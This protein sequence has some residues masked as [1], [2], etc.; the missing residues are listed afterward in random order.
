MDKHNVEKILNMPMPGTLKEIRSFVCLAGY[1]RRFIEGF[2]ELARPLTSLQSK[3]ACARLKRIG[4]NRTK[5]ELPEEVKETVEI[6]KKKITEGPI[7]ALPDF[8][9]PF[10]MR[11]DASQYAIGGVLYQVDEEER[12]H[13]IWF[14]SKTLNATE[15]KW[16]ATEREMLA[17]YTW[18]RYWRPYVWGRAFTVYTDHSPLTGI[19]TR[20]DVTGRLTNMILKLQE[21]DYELKYTPGRTHHVPDALS[22]TPIARRTAE[23]EGMVAPVE[24]RD[25]GEDGYE[26]AVKGE[27]LARRVLKGEEGETKKEGYQVHERQRKAARRNME[28]WGKRRYEWIGS[29]EAI[30]MAQLEDESLEE[31]RALAVERNRKGIWM[32]EEEILFRIRRRK[33]GRE[34]VQLVVPKEWRQK[35]IE[36]EHD[37]KMAGHMGVFKTMER[38][39]RK[40]WWPGMRK[41]VADWIKTCLVC[42]EFKKGRAE[43]KGLLRPIEAYLPFELMGMDILTDLK[44]TKN[45]NKHI[46]VL[47]DYYT[48]W[49][50]AFAIP[51]HEAETLAKI[52]VTKI[53]SRHGAP[54]RIITDRAQDFMADVYRQIT[55]LINTKHSPMT[56]YHPQTDGQ[57]ERMIGT[58][59]GILARIAETEN[60]WD[61][62]LPYALW[63]YRVRCTR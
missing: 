58:I 42:Q 28:E 21:Y 36:M 55:E 51:N 15:Q 59:T 56:P 46:V 49:P 31:C 54:E 1:Y 34:D 44:V 6:L 13:P 43:K 9:R 35:A 20:K 4:G 41:D 33:R 8:D 52:I 27:E 14:A 62:Q 47:T 26:E 3:E 12:E 63:A 57:T 61:E 38:V 24:G 39:A 29:L 45:G 50:E 53:M 60:D 11:T 32:I 25:D 19:K 40:Y 30:S 7:L 10:G 23:G 17:V 5:F 16:S 2:A 22:R 48:K 37:T 18:I